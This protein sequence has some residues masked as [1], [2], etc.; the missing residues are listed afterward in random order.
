VKEMAYSSM[1]IEVPDV[2]EVLGEI[3]EKGLEIVSIVHL[4]ETQQLLVVTKDKVR[5]FRSMQEDADEDEE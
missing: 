2:A 1:L 4:S 5:K 3:D